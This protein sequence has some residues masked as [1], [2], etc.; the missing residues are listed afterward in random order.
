MDDLVID[1]GRRASVIDGALAN[2]L[3]HYLS[4]QTAE[5]T[6]AAIRRRRDAGAYDGLTT[7]TALR[8][9][10]NTD[11]LDASKDKHV[12]VRYHVRPQPVPQTDNILDDPAVLERMR[13]ASV[14]HNYGFARVER[15][16]GNVGYLDLRFF[17]PLEW[18]GC[19][20]IAAAAMTFVSRTSALIIDVRKNGGGGQGL[21]NFLASY[22]LPA[23]PE[24][25]IHLC[26]YYYGARLEQ[27]W[28][29]P[30]VPGPRYQ[31]KPLYI[32]TSAC[33][34]SAAEEFAYVLQA[35]R[36]ATIV[37][38]TTA[39]AANLVGEY[40]IDARFSIFVSNGR[41]VIPRT[42]GNWEGTGVAPDIVAPERD[43]AKVAHSAALERILATEDASFPSALT[44]EARA[45]LIALQGAP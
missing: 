45:A 2:L 8:D 38:D 14:T 39:G 17:A 11:L 19:G 25:P 37:G 20:D 22:F 10:L 16:S 32:L 28:T 23:V 31:T 7:A 15:L 40:H 26:D 41:V 5:D 27:Q 35:L 24:H 9:A 6:V 18:S 30:H 29:I 13:L 34:I 42:G 1:A 21:I 36:R 33:T 3:E 12:Q 44:D 43:A 4:P